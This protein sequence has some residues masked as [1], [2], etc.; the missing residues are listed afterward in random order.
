MEG[1]GDRL[2][3]GASSAIFGPNTDTKISDEKWRA[4]FEGF[5]AEDFKKNGFRPEGSTG[6]KERTRS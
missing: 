1:Y 4:A 2:A 6:K 3:R 5:D